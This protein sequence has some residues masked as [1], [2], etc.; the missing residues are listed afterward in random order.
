MDTQCV[1]QR[2]LAPF[3]LNANGEA[4]DMIEVKSISKS[5]KTVN[6]LSELTFAARDGEI[7][8]LLGPNGA[9]K[10]TC[11]RIIYGLLRADSG[12]AL[13]EHVD[14]NKHPLKARSNLG[15][16]LINSVFM[17]V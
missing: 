9:G 2:K 10:T 6:A 17:N 1:K 13:I 4:F 8:G 5:F 3:V 7:T 14:A 12:E 16:F 11:L 15:I